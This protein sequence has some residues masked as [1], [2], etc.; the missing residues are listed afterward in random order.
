MRRV[1]REAR[2][3]SIPLRELTYHRELN[4]KILSGCPVHYS[5]WKGPDLSGP[6][7]SAEERV[8]AYP[9]IGIYCGKG[10]SHSWLWFVELFDRYGFYDLAPLD[11]DQIRGGAL[12]SI[13]CLA[14]S[15]GD[16]I[17]MAEGLGKEGAAELGSFLRQGGLYLGSCAGAYLP[18]NSSKEHLH[19]F[20]FVKARITNLTK[21]VPD[22]VRLPEKSI[23]PYGCSYLFHPVREA[24]E[25][26]AH[27]LP[28]FAGMGSFSA[29]LFGGPGM[30][31]GGG[32][33][34]LARY[35]GFTKKTL[36]LVDP[37]LARET[38]IDKAAVVKN[39][40]GQG[41]FYLFGP[42]FEHPYFP[43]ANK[44]VTDCIYW[45]L[46]GLLEKKKKGHKE[47][48]LTVLSGTELTS[49]LKG[50]KREVS[51]ARIVANGLETYS[52]HWLIGNK[53]Y[54]PVKIRF[55]LEAV[56][57]RLGRIAPWPELKILKEEENS[58]TDEAVQLT[59]LLRDLKNRI[60]DGQETLP[61]A[62]TLFQKLQLFTRKFLK[63]FFRSE[64]SA[65]RGSRN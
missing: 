52:I 51:N 1:T 55:F 50:L 3:D 49:W 34:V 11:E 46:G 20:N 32:S 31:P 21:K 8:L 25:L 35:S 62:E 44:L 41:A 4:R 13:D 47:P 2:K 45:E 12:G 30:I 17:A 33:E 18:L 36:F 9:R 28:P 10:C 37:D 60:D 58:L 27:G 22:S 65:F 40:W 63:I 6:D 23:I 42:H 19:H 26:T 5:Q 53:I 29:P 43:V 48:S 57:K 54:E 56:W 59:V 14:V 61:V 15:G 38:L 16:T 7:G 39:S 64:L 24:V